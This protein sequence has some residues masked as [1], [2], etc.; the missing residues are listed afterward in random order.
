M[1]PL[2]KP[3]HIPPVPAGSGPRPF[4]SVAIPTYNAP[5]GY[6]ETTLRSVLNQ[7][8]GADAMQILVVDDC[9]PQQS[10]E[11]L[12]RRIGDGRV[13]FYREEKNLGLAGIWNSCITRSRGE[14]VHILHQDD[15]VLPGFYEGFRRGLEQNPKV[16][17]AFCR[18][19]FIDATGHQDF[20]SELERTSSGMLEN[21]LERIAVEQV[22]QTP[23]IVVKRAVYEELGGFLPELCF[24]L[25]WEMWRRIAARYPFWYEAE[26]R[27]CY[28]IHGT[29]ATS[30][31]TQ[32]A[33]DIDDNVRSIEIAEGYMPKESARSLTR[34]AKEYYAIRAVE[35]AGLLLNKGMVASAFAQVRGALKCSPSLKVLARVAKFGVRSCL[36][37]LR[38]SS[39]L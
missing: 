19:A 38:P 14:W 34:K 37:R 24:A 6:F 16:G 15:L 33:L 28:R 25:D 21:W 36:D 18:H 8:P 2:I 4:W 10:S 22:I 32:A 26:V 23:A 12:V 3:A 13:E 31:L 1:K 39:S 9:S 20:L 27:A 17:A 11:E 7:A 5:A 35:K 30:R 29:S